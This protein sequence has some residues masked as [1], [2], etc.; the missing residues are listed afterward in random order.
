MCE[1]MSK[2]DMSFHKFAFQRPN[3]EL[4]KCLAGDLEGMDHA[5]VTVVHGQ[6]S[7]KTP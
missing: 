6:A 7:M 2:A 5:G 1:L 4:D 3:F